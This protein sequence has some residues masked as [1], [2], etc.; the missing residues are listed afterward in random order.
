VDI[1]FD[2]YSYAISLNTSLESVIIDLAHRCKDIKEV[3]GVIKLYAIPYSLLRTYYN[4]RTSRVETATLSELVQG[5]F[6]S[7]FM[8]YATQDS[9]GHAE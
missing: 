5:A 2:T 3:I 8:V 4:L 7:L 6:L 9:H 1:N